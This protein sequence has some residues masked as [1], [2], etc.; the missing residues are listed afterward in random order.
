M[1]IESISSMHDIAQMQRE[2]DQRILDV[3]HLTVEETFRKRIL[4]FLVELG[5]LAN[6]TRCFKFWSLKLSSEK[7]VVLDEYVDGIHFL[8]SLGNDMGVDFSTMTFAKTGFSD[9]SEGFIRI[10]QTA[11][12]FAIH[13]AVDVFTEL[14]DGYMRLGYSLGFTFDDVVSGYVNKNKINHERQNSQY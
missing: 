4:A 13:M 11:S 14:F 6:E 10:Y 7:S 5:E 1:N 2:L 3:H 9:V 12:S 8:M